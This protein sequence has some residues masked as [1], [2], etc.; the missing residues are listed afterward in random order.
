M[1]FRIPTQVTIASGCIDTVSEHLADQSRVLLIVDEGLQSTPWPDRVNRLVRGA[2]HDVAIVTGIEQN[3]RYHTID[4][5]SDAFRDRTVDAVI[6]LG[7]G[8]VLDAA[9]A[10]AILLRNP[11]SCLDYEGKN[12]FRNG[13]APFI[14][15]PTTCGTGSEV[16]W[17]SVVT[18]PA[19]QR[20]LSI[21]GEA[22]FPDAALV[23]PELLTTLPAYLVAYTGMDAL[24]HAIEAYT[25]NCSN[26]VSDALAEKAVSLLFAF[27]PR[28][29][30]DIHDATARFEVMRAST[31]AGMA[32]S[33]ADVAA[34]HCLSETIGGLFDV[35]HGLA[36]ALLLAPVMQFH[37]PCIA[38]RLAR[39]HSLVE[40][41]QLLDDS[42]GS[43]AMIEALRQLAV[44]VGIP[45]FASLN[46]P[47]DQYQEI[48][49]RATQNNSNGSNPQPMIPEAYEKIL[50]DL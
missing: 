10:I 16:T 7:G 34:V 21:K 27:L 17:V 33:N 14:A 12:R 2:G 20:K 31:L 3:P 19:H 15:V 49:R 13:S 22:M 24:T 23:D 35:P 8:S 29:V 45:D 41:Q 48:A 9:K 5:I 18:D 39:L 1:A 25:C 40:P 36:N 47:L 43:M 50:N 46:I 6:G 4:K 32:F 30:A 28:A 11:G 42:E 38:A 37:R 26:P 44:K